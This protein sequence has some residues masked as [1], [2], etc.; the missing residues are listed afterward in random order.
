MTGDWRLGT[1]CGL[2]SRDLVVHKIACGIEPFCV[3]ICA[4]QNCVI[5][6]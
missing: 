1:G 4:C 2:K 6:S 3:N 5:F